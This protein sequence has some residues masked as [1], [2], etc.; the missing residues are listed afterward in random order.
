MR[1]LPSDVP[2]LIESVTSDESGPS[3]CSTDDAMPP[4]EITGHAS[5]DDYVH[6]STWHTQ[7]LSTVGAAKYTK[8]AATA[9]TST[10]FYTSDIYPAFTARSGAFEIPCTFYTFMILQITDV[11]NKSLST[12]ITVSLEYLGTVDGRI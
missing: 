1:D 11:L 2:S 3:E 5:S 8:S 6:A 12:I 9:A 10:R 7:P 4:L